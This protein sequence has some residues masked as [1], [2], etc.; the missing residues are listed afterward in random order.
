MAW[1][2]HTRAF[3]DTGSQYLSGSPYIGQLMGFLYGNYAS[4]THVQKH[5]CLN[6]CLNRKRW[7][8][9]EL[10]KVSQGYGDKED[11]NSGFETLL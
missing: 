8:H 5:W 3:V 1:E 4:Q 2:L 11:S 9:E 6:R 10:R 7:Y